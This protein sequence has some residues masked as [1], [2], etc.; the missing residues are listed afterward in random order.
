MY[1]F[2][3]IKQKGGKTKYAHFDLLRRFLYLFD[4]ILNEQLFDYDVFMMYNIS[5]I[6]VVKSRAFRYCFFKFHYG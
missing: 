3:V 2:E 5:C 1:F 4:E 6:L